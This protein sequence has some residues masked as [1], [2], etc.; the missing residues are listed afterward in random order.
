[1]WISAVRL[2]SAPTPNPLPPTHAPVPLDPCLVRLS[3][4][5]FP[6]AFS[7]KA[8]APGP[9]ERSLAGCPW[10]L[11]PPG[12]QEWEAFQGAGLGWSRVAISM[13]CAVPST[14]LL[15]SLTMLASHR[16]GWSSVHRSAPGI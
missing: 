4:C 8:D 9:A 5:L 12:A 2:R 11:V 16:G 6:T 7:Q 13:V 1:M 14:C 3:R 15:A 10:T